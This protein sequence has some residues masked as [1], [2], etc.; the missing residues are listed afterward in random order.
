[1]P[2]TLLATAA[3]PNTSR[4]GVTPNPGLVEAAIR[5]WAPV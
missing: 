2:F 4:R 5:P 3:F 1:M